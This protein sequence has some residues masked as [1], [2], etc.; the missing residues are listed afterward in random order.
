MIVPSLSALRISRPFVVDDVGPKLAD[1][2]EMIFTND[3]VE[4]CLFYSIIHGL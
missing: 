4:L 1:I 3:Y 2:V